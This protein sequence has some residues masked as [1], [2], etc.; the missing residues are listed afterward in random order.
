MGKLVFEINVSSDG[1]ADHT[2]AVGADDEFHVFFGDLLDETDVALF[3][4]V[5]Y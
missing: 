5:T 3:G 1:F 4:L 2:V